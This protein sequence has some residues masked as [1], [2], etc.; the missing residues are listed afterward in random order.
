M[1]C[2]ALIQPPSD[3]NWVYWYDWPVHFDVHQLFV[4]LSFDWRSLAVT[5][6]LFQHQLLVVW[7]LFDVYLIVV[8][9]GCVISSNRNVGLIWLYLVLSVL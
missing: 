2:G 9:V 5:V 3:V 6:F 8:C 7:I 4:G 1:H